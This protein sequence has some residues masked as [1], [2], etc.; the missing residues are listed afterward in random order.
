MKK[1]SLHDIPAEGL[2]IEVIRENNELLPIGEEV[3][4]SI[5]SPILAH[6]QLS[7]SDEEVLITG[8]MTSVLNL[9]CSRCLRKFEHKMNSTIEVVYTIT[10]YEH[11]NN[12]IKD[13]QLKQEDYTDCLKGD[14]IDINT[15]I[16]E[17]LSLDIPMQHL[18]RIDCKGLCSKCGI[19][20]NK[21]RCN[22][23]VEEHIDTRLAKLKELK[24]NIK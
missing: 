7:K 23:F 9:Q 10:G 11:A 22:C 6:L 12:I 17:Q 1:V 21:E 16:L 5:S 24:M 18:C 19:D 3:G 13:K 20:L 8:D 15:I 14:E 4:F 2:Y